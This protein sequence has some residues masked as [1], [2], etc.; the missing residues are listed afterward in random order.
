MNGEKIYNSNYCAACY[1]RTISKYPSKKCLIQLTERCNLH[2][3]HCFVAANSSGKEISFNDIE[4]KILPKLIE[5]GVSKVTL[6]GGEPFTYDRLSDVVF[7]LIENN[8]EVCICT[9]GTLLNND[10]LNK[11]SELDNI[12]FNVSLDGF[13]SKT[14]GKFRGNESEQTFSK[15]VSNIKSLG[16]RNLINGILVTPNIYT[17]ILEYIE[18]CK[19]AIECGANYVL[20]NPLSQFGRGENSKGLAYSNAQMLKLQSLTEQYIKNDFE[21]IYIRFPNIEEK[22]LSQCVAGKISYIFTNGDVAFCPYMAFAAKNENSL[23]SYSDFIIGN[24]FDSTFSLNENLKAY[25]FPVSYEEVCKGC[26]NQKCKKGCFAS[27]ISQGMNLE[28]S[29][30]F[31]CPLSEKY[32]EEPTIEK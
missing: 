8:I 19:L 12:H 26:S 28:S 30:K 32:I 22:P 1:F 14:H 29:D 7:L 3:E 6:T 2:C 4:T 5:G 10:F 20:M 9:N 25:K 24:I 31:L 27:R 21:I 16:K 11:I 23:Y 13:S 18:I 15:I 17:P